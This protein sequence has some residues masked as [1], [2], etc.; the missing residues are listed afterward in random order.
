[1]RKWLLVIIIPVLLSSC[2]DSQSK[3]ETTISN[4]S[5]ACATSLAIIG[6]K[7]FDSISQL[8]I[9][10]ALDVKVVNY[11]SNKIVWTGY[12]DKALSL[13][14]KNSNNKLD[15]SSPEGCSSEMKVTIYTKDKINDLQI[16][17][18]SDVEIENNI[19]SDLFLNLD[20]SGT[21]N[22]YV[23]NNKISKLQLSVSGASDLRIN[24]VADVEMKVSG[25][26][27]VFFKEVERISGQVSGVSAVTIQ[28]KSSPD[29]TQ[30]EL[31]EL[32]TIE[33]IDK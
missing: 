6:E 3:N 15:V 18:A 17:G 1:M 10:S 12:N 26:S 21:S 7:S 25:T 22:V 30:V 13:Q 31:I 24:D 20:V 29:L 27:D 8:R 14:I 16:G 23:Y 5:S 32:G 4:G 2:A 11:K 19:I 33:I 9:S 28:S